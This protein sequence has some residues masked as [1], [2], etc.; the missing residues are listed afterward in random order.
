MENF[1]RTAMRKILRTVLIAMSTNR[2]TSYALHVYTPLLVISCHNV[3]TTSTDVEVIDFF[4][5]AR[6]YFKKKLYL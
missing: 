3:P 6:F 1:V 5:Y 2:E 4:L